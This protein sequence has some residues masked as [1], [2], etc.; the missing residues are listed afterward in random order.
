MICSFDETTESLDELLPSS[1]FLFSFAFFEPIG[2]WVEFAPP[3]SLHKLIKNEENLGDCD[4]GEPKVL[5]SMSGIL[6]LTLSENFGISFI[7]THT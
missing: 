4:V 5:L 6:L 3:S 2:R 7:N 1:S